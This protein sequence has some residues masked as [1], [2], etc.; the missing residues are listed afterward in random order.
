MKIIA[1]AGLNK[2]KYNFLKK[3]YNSVKILNLTDDNFFKN[4]DINL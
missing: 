2:E 3:K 4:K 1:I